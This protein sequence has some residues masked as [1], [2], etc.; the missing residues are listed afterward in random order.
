[1][2]IGFV[3]CG[4]IAHAHAHHVARY[5][6]EKILVGVCDI[7]PQRARNFAEKFGIESVYTELDRFLNDHKLDVVHVLSPPQTHAALALKLMEAGS[8]VLVEKPMALSTEEADTMIKVAEV[9]RVKLCVN[10]NLLFDPV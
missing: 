10:H 5:N 2:K 3:G 6:H 4:D 1:M 8:H 9:N 7:D